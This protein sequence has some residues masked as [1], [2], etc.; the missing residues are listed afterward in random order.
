MHLFLYFHGFYSGNGF[1]L[2]FDVEV[3]VVIVVVA[4]VVL[5]TFLDF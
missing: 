4:V 2:Y 5:D 3:I 1:M